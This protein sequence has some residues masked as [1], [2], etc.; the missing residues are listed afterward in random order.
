MEITD[1]RYKY[2]EKLQ[3][4]LSQD[5]FFLFRLLNKVVPQKGSALEIGVFCG[6][7]LVG[8]AL[9]FPKISR[10]VGVDPF[11]QDFT[12]SPALPG[13]DHDLTAMSQYMS[14]DERISNLAEVVNHIDV[15]QDT[16]ISQKIKLMKMT[17]DKYLQTKTKST[18]FTI[19]HIDGEHTFEAVNN[20]LDSLPKIMKKGGIVIVD[21][22]L[23]I[24]YPGIAESVFTHGTFKKS[25]LPIL[26]A[27]NKGVFL[28]DVSEKY[29]QSVINDL[30][31]LLD[32]D[33]YTTRK[34][35]DD[36][37]MVY[38]Q[39]QL[40]ISTSSSKTRMI[41]IANKFRALFG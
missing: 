16:N 7:S 32:N 2:L 10:L 39:S 28:Y 40:R 41:R 36:S 24:G 27:F 3:G 38:R 19:C 12:E 20:L 33:I 9:A 29:H 4:Y 23:N 13:E 37:L 11:Y 8:L 34:L 26:Y 15:Q 18:K 30:S 5:A 17:Q 21:D 14:R 35:H 25:L 22:I 1:N 31:S 6:R